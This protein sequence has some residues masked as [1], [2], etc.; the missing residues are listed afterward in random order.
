[1]PSTGLVSVIIPTRD[2]AE[3]LAGTVSAMRAQTYPAIEIVI[4]DDGSR[5]GTPELINEFVRN[6]P[7]MRGLRHATSSGAA[8]ARNTGAAVARGQYLLFEDDDCR[9]EPEKVAL[10]V[11]ALEQAPDAAYAYCYWTTRMLPDHSVTVHDPDEPWS[12]ATPAALIRT[13]AFHAAGRFDP[14]LPRLQDFD[15]WSR[16]LARAP[17]VAVPRVLFEM[18]RDHTGISASDENLLIASERILTKYRGSDLP[19]SHLAAMHRRLGGKLVIL[20][21]RKEGLAH[22]LRS[23]SIRRRSLRSWVA[24]IAGVAGPPAYRGVARV[25]DRLKDLSAGRRR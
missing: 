14:A 8:A 4:V 25:A 20:G 1:M 15:L 16:L 13:E 17:A 10:L 19:P 3:L 12:M 9:A 2:R 18:T 24:L 6:H 22:L 5:D 23:V 11:D 7:G 21:F